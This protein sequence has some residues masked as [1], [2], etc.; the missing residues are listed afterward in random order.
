MTF[1][2]Y[3]TVTTGL[4]KALMVTLIPTISEMAPFMISIITV[5]ECL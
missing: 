2:G 4:K 3:W 1:L 5:I